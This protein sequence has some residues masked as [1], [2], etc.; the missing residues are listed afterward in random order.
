[1]T[2]YRKNGPTKE[3]VTESLPPAGRN[4]PAAKAYKNDRR[5]GKTHP[6]RREMRVSLNRPRPLWM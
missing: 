1:M 5:S 2:E 6:E 3:T 4:T